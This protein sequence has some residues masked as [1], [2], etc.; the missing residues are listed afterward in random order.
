M[1]THTTKNPE[2]KRTVGRESHSRREE[3]ELST[4]KPMSLKKKNR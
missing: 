3:D 1:F 2:K 4:D